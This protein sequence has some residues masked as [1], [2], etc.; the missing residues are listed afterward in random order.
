VSYR[1]PPQHKKKHTV[2]DDYQLRIPDRSLHLD[3][4]RVSQDGLL[5]YLLRS[6]CGNCFLWNAA[7]SSQERTSGKFFL[8]IEIINI[9]AL[10]TAQMAIKLSSASL[11]AAAE[12]TVPAFTFILSVFWFKVMRQPTEALFNHFIAKIMITFVMVLGVLLI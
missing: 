9:F 1:L 12:T 10:C 6:N 4:C 8:I 7:H 3:G 11:V 2:S 5:H